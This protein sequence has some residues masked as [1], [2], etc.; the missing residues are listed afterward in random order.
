ML[1]FT[2]DLLTSFTDGLMDVNSEDELANEILNDII[3]N[4]QDFY[5][6]PNVPDKEYEIFGNQ[7]RY[8]INSHN[9]A[10]QYSKL[11]DSITAEEV[12]SLGISSPGNDYL[13][14]AKNTARLGKIL[15]ANLIKDLKEREDRSF[16]LLEFRKYQVKGLLDGGYFSL[17]MRFLNSIIQSED[18]QLGIFAYSIMISSF[19]S[20]Y[21][22]TNVNLYIK[23]ILDNITKFDNSPDYIIDD[24]IEDI[25]DL[26]TLKEIIK[27]PNFELYF[28]KSS[29]YLYNPDSLVSFK[30]TQEYP[31]LFIFNYYLFL[32]SYA[33]RMK[34]MIDSNL[35]I[36]L[37]VLNYLLESNRKE[38]IL[39]IRSYNKYQDNL[40][41]VLNKLDFSF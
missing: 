33:H 32:Y 6:Y 19:K 9:L 3:Q 23:F 35:P 22:R 36:S 34:I 25:Q 1:G 12:L 29:L 31:N 5:P 17:C 14:L 2:Y 38:L 30:I 26:L 4:P 40:N 41:L 28:N 15:N 11:P 18:P 37:N 16:D 20:Y 24:L 39:A 8:K 13:M 27:H 10:V 21:N 7:L